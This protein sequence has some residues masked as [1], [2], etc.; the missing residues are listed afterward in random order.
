MPADPSESGRTAAQALQMERADE[1]VR[2]AAA[3]ELARLDALEAA[4]P[5]DV[6]T[7]ALLKREAERAAGTGQEDRT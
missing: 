7:L 5:V 3:V 1:P 2:R 6:G 4:R